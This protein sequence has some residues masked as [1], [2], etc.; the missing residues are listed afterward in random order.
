MSLFLATLVG[1]SGDS[2]VPS[3][4]ENQENLTDTE[5]QDTGFPAS[6]EDC[7]DGLDNDGDGRTDCE[8]ADCYEACT[9]RDCTDGLDND[10]DAWV[11]CEDEDCW[12]EDSCL[13]SIALL[14]GSGRITTKP[15][16]GNSSGLL[17]ASAGIRYAEGSAE[18]PGESSTLLC[19]WSADILLFYTWSWSGSSIEPIGLSSTGACGGRVEGLLTANEYMGVVDQ[20]N[21][22]IDFVEFGSLETEG[23][24]IWM[25]GAEFVHGAVTSTRWDD[26]RDWS[27]RFQVS[28]GEPWITQ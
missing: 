14:S 18:V 25:G 19:N 20:Y 24:L 21:F 9:E 22:G 26:N 11:D 10:A 17:F 28:P 15:P 4:P 2:R 3:P 23:P 8:D 13:A 27:A 5:T 1:C 7:R 16:W 12:G 6:E